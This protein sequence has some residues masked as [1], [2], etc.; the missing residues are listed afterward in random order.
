MIEEIEKL[1]R[2]ERA[3]RNTELVALSSLIW[4]NKGRVRR[5][6]FRRLERE[7]KESTS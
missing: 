5:Q 3:L 1:N 2:K 4:D 7:I 6:L